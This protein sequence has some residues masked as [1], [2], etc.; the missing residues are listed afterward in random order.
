MIKRRFWLPVFISLIAIQHTWIEPIA[1][2]DSVAWN[3]EIRLCKT[4]NGRNI[5][6]GT[7]FGSLLFDPQESYLKIFILP[8]NKN[9]IWVQF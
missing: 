3:L 1:M 9:T 7:H 6:S 8:E 4:L 5:D 2:Y